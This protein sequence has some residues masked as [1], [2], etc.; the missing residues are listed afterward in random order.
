MRMTYLLYTSW[1]PPIHHP[2]QPAP[3]HTAHINTRTDPD[4]PVWTRTG[5]NKVSNSL[6]W[7]IYHY[8]RLLSKAFWTVLLTYLYLKKTREIQVMIFFLLLAACI[9]WLILTRLSPFLQFTF[10]PKTL[11]LSVTMDLYMIRPLYMEFIISNIYMY[12]KTSV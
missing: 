8:W 3:T 2:H 11:R 4:G 10:S 12:S 9:S 5:Q 7:I 1:T 6:F